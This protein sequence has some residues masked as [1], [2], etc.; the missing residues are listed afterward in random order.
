VTPE[1]LAVVQKSYTKTM[2]SAQQDKKQTEQASQ[3]SASKDSAKDQG[4]AKKTDQSGDKSGASSAGQQAKSS[5]IPPG[6]QKVTERIKTETTREYLDAQGKVIG[7]EKT[8][9]DQVKTVPPEMLK[10]Q[11]EQAKDTSQD[12]GSSSA[13]DQ[14]AAGK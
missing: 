14:G 7:T 4:Q 11:A 13:K 6:V 8:T 12:Q 10:Q 2:Q 9:N 3:A 1:N 5:A